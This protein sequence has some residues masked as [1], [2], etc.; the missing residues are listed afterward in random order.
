MAVIVDAEVRNDIT[1]ASAVC[2][3]GQKKKFK[4]HWR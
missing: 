1:N 2:R 3:E 4:H